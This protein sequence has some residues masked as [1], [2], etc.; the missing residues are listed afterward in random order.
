MQNPVFESIDQAVR[1]SS[2]AAMPKEIS[3]VDDILTHAN[4]GVAALAWSWSSGAVGE[5]S[6][7][8]LTILFISRAF[9]SL[10]RARE[11][12]V[13]GYPVQCLALCRTAFEDFAAMSYIEQHPEKRQVWLQAIFPKTEW[14][15]Q[16][17][18]PKELLDDYCRAAPVNRQFYHM[19]S[20]YVHPTGG[21]L[22]HHFDW[23][24][25]M[26]GLFDRRELKMCLMWLMMI[27]PLLLG[28]LAPLRNRV[29]GEPVSEWDRRT[30]E[31]SEEAQMPL[32]RLVDEL[33]TS[34]AE[35]DSHAAETH[36]D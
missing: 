3:V 28:A 31:I 2:L 17:P 27:A 29:L 12:A 6:P 16:E 36:P 21:Q 7:E 4:D 18:R 34:F 5:R 9:K 20:E 13:C 22:S 23:T 14:P 15:G 25:H 33:L 19:L 11:D 10:W 26:A 35:D 30:D 32:G 8:F 24:T 1:D